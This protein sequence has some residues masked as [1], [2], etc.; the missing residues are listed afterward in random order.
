MPTAYLNR[1]KLDQLLGARTVADAI[2]QSEA[3][4][5]SVI[6]AVSAIA[7]GYVSGQLVLPLSPTAIEQVAPLVAELVYCAL[8]SADGS[9]TTAKRKAEA[10]KALR[11]I[12]SGT[13]RLHS[14][15]LPDDPATPE[16]ESLSGAAC[17]AGP[18]LISGLYKLNQDDANAGW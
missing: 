14:E 12:S 4:I 1:Q 18:R 10:M 5:D 15:P 2:A 11:D 6:A 17:G 3:D 7:D 13:F 16:N 9:E 8:Y